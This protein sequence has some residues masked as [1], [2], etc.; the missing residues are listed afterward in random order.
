MT[1]VNPTQFSDNTTHTAAQHNNPINEI[2]AAI[3]GE[4]E[5]ENISATAAIDAGK[6]A[7]GVSGMF[8]AWTTWTPTY[9]N[10][11]VGN[12]TATASYIKI[13]KTVHFSYTLVLG[14]TSAIGTSPTFTLPT[15]AAS[16]GKNGFTAYALDS[17]TSRVPLFADT[18]GSTTIV[19]LFAV[20]TVGTY[21]A[22]STI[23]ST[24]PFT[25]TT[26]DELHVNGSYEAA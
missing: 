23:S 19:G 7:G 1:L 8:G 4:I 11:T 17:G 22:Q 6:L 18:F 26:S 16:S 5:N 12:G 2:A 21:G 15:A 10:I 24:V 20:N 14:S 13:G 25:W 9:A 3:N